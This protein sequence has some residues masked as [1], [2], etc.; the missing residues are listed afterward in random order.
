MI[1]IAVAL[2]VT[3]FNPTGLDSTSCSGPGPAGR[4][5]SRPIRIW[6]QVMPPAPMT[7][8]A[9]D[10]LVEEATAI[11]APYNVSL[12]LTRARSDHSDRDG[13]VLKLFVRKAATNRV[14]GKPTAGH[15]GLAAIT[16]VD[17]VH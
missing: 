13:H 6:L 12:A 10:L 14:D 11:W 5:E 16:F 9:I 8:C 15:H 4:E 17:G 3:V 7:P 2:A 1:A